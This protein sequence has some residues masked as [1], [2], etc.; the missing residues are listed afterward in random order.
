MEVLIYTCGNNG[1]EHFAPLFIAAALWS[2][3]SNQVEFGV[4]NLTAFDE[5][6]AISFL[7]E[8]FPARFNL[9]QVS[10][11]PTTVPHALRFVTA[12]E[13]KAPYVYIVDSDLVMLDQNFPQEHLAF[14]QRSG[15][16]Y[17]NTIR[18]HTR[19]MTGLHFS[20]WDSYYPLPDISDLNLRMNDER[21]LAEI[22]HR[23]GLALH[24]EP[25]FRPVPG[26]HPSPNRELTPSAKDG[27]LLPGWGVQPWIFQWARFRSDLADLMPLLSGKSADV[28][29]AIDLAV[30]PNPARTTFTRVVKERTLAGAESVCGSGST[31]AATAELLPQLKKVFER[32]GIV[33]LS[34]A[35]CGDFNWIGPLAQGVSYRGF[36]LLEEIVELA[37]SRSSHHFT[38]LDI[39]SEILPRADA[40]LCRDCLVH[41]PD[42]MIAAT[43]RNFV[44]SGS[45]WLI[46][47]T[48]PDVPENRK[49]SMAGWRPINLQA[50][51]FNFP[52]PVEIIFERPSVPS[53]VDYGRKALGVWR[54]AELT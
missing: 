26:I 31:V 40:I 11:P 6:P 29:K 13:R 22:V 48:F 34:D 38:V 15:L 14:L 33:S 27:R 9:T 30:G 51:P 5:D 28:V 23:N 4:P 19:R 2:S 41:L 39:A 1:Y 32:H 7:Q 36:D 12:P 43:F 46:T 42:D 21:V 18:P 3:D 20:R 54:L 47:T 44:R 17:A 35:P 37:R 49:S 50:P 45:G 53:H 10:F 16:P 52:E 8:R 24:E 25:W